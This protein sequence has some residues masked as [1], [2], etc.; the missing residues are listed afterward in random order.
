M[1]VR[2]LAVLGT[3][4][5]VPTRERAHNGLLL[6]WDRHGILVDPGEGT[7]RQ[8]TLAGLPAS[9][10]TRIPARGVRR[11]W[12]NCL[13]K[14]MSEASHAV[15]T[16]GAPRGPAGRGVVKVDMTGSLQPPESSVPA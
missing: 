14:A 15:A 4:S 7:Q 5:Q 2:E 3:A 13:R 16:G 10:I 1:S 12:S 9:A 11:S 6:R 8:L